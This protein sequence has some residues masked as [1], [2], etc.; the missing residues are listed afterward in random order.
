MRTMIF[1]F[2]LLGAVLSEPPRTKIMYGSSEN[3]KKGIAHIAE[4]GTINAFGILKTKVIHRIYGG[5]FGPVNIIAKME[6]IDYSDVISRYIN[7][8]ENQ[9][10]VYVFVG[11]RNGKPEGLCDS[12]S[13]D[14]C[15]EIYITRSIDDGKTWSF[16]VIIR[17]DSM[18]DLVQRTFPSLAYDRVTGKIYMAYGREV[19]EEGKETFNIGMVE[20]GPEDVAF[21]DEKIVG[22]NFND[23]LE[24]PWS[25][26]K[27][28]ITKP[29]ENDTVFHLLV[30]GGVDATNEV[31]YGRSTDGKYWTMTKV[32]EAEADKHHSIS[33]AALGAVGDKNVY[34]AHTTDKNTWLYFSDDNGENWSEP[35]KIESGAKLQF[36]K[37]CGKE[38]THGV[39]ISFFQEDEEKSHDFK[40][41]K[42][43][44][45]EEIGEHKPFTELDKLK[46]L[47]MFDCI[48]DDPNNVFYSAVTSYGSSVLFAMHK[49]I[50][51]D[52]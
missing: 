33:I 47:P 9:V 23:L 36:L 10:I 17:R 46:A 21:S 24:E 7:S 32:D 11:A 1:V 3:V 20:M 25:H 18:S 6:G 5:H 8:E 28:T 48:S 34:F 41:F 31:F 26:P 52:T 16:P 45:E 39:M 14:G 27:L 50:F 43:L 51:E 4:S 38:E 40:Y 29:K 30:K 13:D 19:K 42:K 2:F 44:E 37:V 22:L 15:K 35:K 49:I 12:T